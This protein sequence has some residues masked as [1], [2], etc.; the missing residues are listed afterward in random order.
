MANLSE[1]TEWI[2]ELYELALA[3][4]VSGGAYNP[5]TKQGI[6]NHPHAQLAS[7]TR[8]L[9]AEVEARWSNDDVSQNLSEN[10]YVA[11]PSGLVLQWGS[12]VTFDANN[13]GLVVFPIAFP[14]ACLQV[15]A[16][17]VVQST[18]VETHT[19]VISV[20]LVSRTTFRLT[21]RLPGQAGRTTS[22]IRYFAVG[23]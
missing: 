18:D 2:E 14:I 19:H 7:R 17:D 22:G 4:P 16:T 12:A 1:G 8:Y 6:D 15:V 9:K 5:V 13:L 11:L 20:Y 10:G 21:A 23:H 3:D